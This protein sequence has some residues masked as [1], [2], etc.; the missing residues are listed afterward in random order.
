MGGLRPVPVQ[1]DG[2]L[3]QPQPLRSSTNGTGAND[4]VDF[5]EDCGGDDSGW[6]LVKVYRYWTSTYSCSSPYGLSFSAHL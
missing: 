6:Y 2:R 1:V 4:S 3:Q 5:Q